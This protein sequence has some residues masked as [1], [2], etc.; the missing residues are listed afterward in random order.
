MLVTNNADDA[1]S[2]ADAVSSHSAS[3]VRRRYNRGAGALAQSTGNIASVAKSMLILDTE[4]TQ[5][6]NSRAS[7]LSRPPTKAIELDRTLSLSRHATIGRNGEFQNL[8]KEDR[9]RLSGIEYRSLKLLLKIVFGKMLSS[10]PILLRNSS[11]DRGTNSQ[12]T[13]LACT[14]LV[15]S[16][17]LAGSNMPVPSTRTY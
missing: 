16:A 15:P 5:R 7:S 14:S 9:Q 2:K 13:S 17:S 4:R 12:R 8:T 6:R 10:H 11:S 3:D 1:I